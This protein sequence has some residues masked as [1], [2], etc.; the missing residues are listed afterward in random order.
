MN[1]AVSPIRQR[2]N[3]IR[4]ELSERREARARYNAMK[5]DLASYRTP[6]EID[7]LLG[8]IEYQE[9]PEAPEAQQ[10]QEIL[11]RTSADRPSSTVAW[12]GRSRCQIR[13]V[14]DRSARASG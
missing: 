12:P 3:T 13:E 9:G 8:V 1:I 7:D 6:R 2:I 11:F 4:D 5:R 10:I 14:G